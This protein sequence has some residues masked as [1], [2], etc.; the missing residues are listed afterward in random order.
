[1]KNRQDYEALRRY[2]MGELPEEETDRLEERMLADDELFE[3]ACAAEEE[4]LDD[5]A[6]GKLRRAE[7]DGLAARLAQSPGGRQ[8]LALARAL[9][10]VPRPQPQEEKPRRVKVAALAAGLAAA[11]LAT[12][13]APRVAGPKPSVAH[14]TLQALRGADYDQQVKPVPGR[15]TELRV[16]LGFAAP[17]QAF[18]ADIATTAGQPVWH[19]GGLRTADD[20]MTLV[21]TLPADRLAP[22]WHRLIVTRERGGAKR[23][24]DWQIE[25][26][27]VH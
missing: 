5:C 2:L 21:L 18:R 8:R 26:E 10:K 24:R 25:F 12:V 19:Q 7:C 16:D 15:P 9:T 3:L 23:T 17:G 1:M 6:R 11:L 22:G 13:I 20:G 4:I 14:L 27:A